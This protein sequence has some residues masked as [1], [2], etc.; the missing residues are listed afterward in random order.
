MSGTATIGP[1]TTA[2][3]NALSAAESLLR[4]PANG[5][6]TATIDVIILGDLVPEDDETVVLQLQPP[7]GLAPGVNPVIN[8]SASTSTI[9]IAAND[10]AAGV[11]DFNTQLLPP[12]PIVEPATFSL[13]VERDL[14]LGGAFYSVDVAWEIANLTNAL[15]AGISPVNGTV[16]FFVGDTRHA[17][18]FTV[19]EDVAPEVPLSITMQ[20]TGTTVVGRPDLSALA[21][22]GSRASV[23]LQ[24]AESDFPVGVFGFLGTEVVVNEPAT[25]T[26]T[27][28]VNVIRRF[29]N[30]GSVTLQWTVDPR[31]AADVDPPHAGTL[32]FGDGDSVRTQSIALAIKADTIPELIERIPVSLSLVSAVAPTQTTNVTSAHLLNSSTSQ[33]EVVVQANDFPYGLVQFEVGSVNVIEPATGFNQ[34]PVTLRRVGGIDILPSAALIRWEW[35]DPGF[36]TRTDNNIRQQSGIQGSPQVVFLTGSAREVNISLLVFPDQCPEQSAQTNLTLNSVSLDGTSGGDFIGLS[37][38]APVDFQIRVLPNGFPEGF[39]GVESVAAGSTIDEGGNFTFS[40]AR[41]QAIL[42]CASESACCFNGG[43]FGSVSATWNLRCVGIN[44]SLGDTNTISPTSGVLQFSQ[45]QVSKSVSISI[46]N[47]SAPVLQQDY[48]VEVTALSP[49]VQSPD[50][51]GIDSTRASIVV[52]VAES[53]FP[54]GRFRIESGGTHVEGVSPTVLATVFRDFGMVGAVTVEVV[55]GGISQGAFPPLDLGCGSS[56]Q[57]TFP[58]DGVT[59][60][61]NVTCTVVPDNISELDELFGVTLVALTPGSAVDPASDRASFTVAHS[62]SPFGT[63]SV[64]SASRSIT[65][66]ENDVILVQIERTAPALGSPIVTLDVERP[67]ELGFPTTVQFANGSSTA[68]FNVSVFDDAI[69][70]PLETVALSIDTFDG[71]DGVGQLSSELTATFTIPEHGPFSGVFGFAPGSVRTQIESSA[72]VTVPFTIVRNLASA[73]SVRLQLVAEDIASCPS[74]R[75]TGITIPQPFIDFIPGSLSQ[76]VDVIV[77]ADNLPELEQCARLRLVVIS[78]TPSCVNDACVGLDRSEDA[79]V[80]IP[81]NDDPYGLFA[82][83]GP[84]FDRGFVFEG[85]VVPFQIERLRGTHG[86][87]SGVLNVVAGAPISGLSS[88]AAVV[89]QISAT[90]VQ[91][92]VS[93]ADGDQSPQSVSIAIADDGAPEDNSTLTYAFDAAATTGNIAI[94]I[95][96][97]ITLIDNDDPNGILG[98]PISVFPR[99]VESS[100]LIINVTR[101]AGLF[102][103]VSADWRLIGNSSDFVGPISG[104]VTFDDGQQ[105]ASFSLQIRSDDTPETQQTYSVELGN[106]TGGATIDP[107]QRSASLTIPENDDPYGVFGLRSVSFATTSATRTIEV[108]VERLF[109]TTGTVDIPII[110]RFG[111]IGDSCAVFPT[112]VAQVTPLVFGPTVSVQHSSILINT[113]Y[114][115]RAGSTFCIELGAPVLRGTAT[116]PPTLV[117]AAQAVNATVPRIVA[118]TTFVQTN[119]TTLSR[120]E[121]GTSLVCEVDRIGGTFGTIRIPW[122]LAATSSGFNASDVSTTSAVLEIAH[123]I[124]ENAIVVLILVDGVPEFDETFSLTF[125][126]LQDPTTVIDMALSNLNGSHPFLIPENEFPYGLFEP[127]QTPL[128]VF[129]GDTAQVTLVRRGGTT[130]AF[131]IDFRTVDG[132]AVAYRDFANTAPGTLSF[133]EG[134]TSATFP[135]SILRP[136]TTEFRSFSVLFFNMRFSSPSNGTL[137]AFLGGG[138]NMTLPITIV[139]CDDPTSPG[140]SLCNVGFEST[141]TL[142]LPEGASVNLR[143][144]RT[145]EAFGELNVTWQL[146]TGTAGSAD[147]GAASQGGLLQ[148]AAEERVKL[149]PVVILQDGLPELSEQAS[150]HL[151]TVTSPLGALT[152][153]TVVTIEIPANDV[154]YGTIGIHTTGSQSS[155]NGGRLGVPPSARPVCNE[156]LTSPFPSIL[157]SWDQASTTC[158]DACQCLVLTR[159]GYDPL[160]S[161][162]RVYVEAY[163]TQPALDLFDVNTGV[164]GVTPM[165]PLTLTTSAA[166]C[167]ELCW[168][169]PTSTCTAFTV[170]SVANGMQE[171]HLYGVGGFTTGVDSLRVFYSLNIASR[172][173][174]RPF[175][176]FLPG[177]RAFRITSSS[178]LVFIPADFLNDTVPELSESFAYRIV[179]VSVIDRTDALAL[180]LVAINQTATTVNATILSN[181]SPHGIVG[182]SPNS[183]TITDEP[184]TVT[185]NLTRTE[186]AFGQVNVTVGAR[187]S[188]VSGAQAEFGTDYRFLSSIATFDDQQR[189]ATVTVDIL[190][191]GIP[192]IEETFTVFPVSATGGAAIDSSTSATLGISQND[193]AEGR[194]SMDCSIVVGLSNISLPTNASF[195]STVI[196]NEGDSVYCV[197]TRSAGLFGTNTVQF[198]TQAPAD[199]TRLVDLDTGLGFG[200]LVF[201]DQGSRTQ[202]FSISVVDDGLPQQVQDVSISIVAVSPVV[203]VDVASAFFTVNESDFPNG[204]FSIATNSPIRVEERD[205]Q[206]LINVTIVRSAG[207]FDSVDVSFQLVD[208]TTFSSSNTQIAAD[209]DFVQLTPVVQTITFAQGQRAA[210]VSVQIIDDLITESA[211]RFSL[212]LVGTTLG[213][214]S[215]TE[216]LIIDII[217][218]QS[219]GPNEY[220][221]FGVENTSI[222][223]DESNTSAIAITRTDGTFGNVTIT[224]Q[225]G[226]F[227]VLPLFSF[228][229]NGTFST[230]FQFTQILRTFSAATLEHCA[231][232]VFPP[233]GG[234]LVRGLT[235]V[236][237]N[238]NHFCLVVLQRVLPNDVVFSNTTFSNTNFSSGGGSVYVLPHP[239]T[240]G[241]SVGDLASN[242]TTINDFVSGVYSVTF[243][244]EQTTLNAPLHITDDDVPEDSER[245]WFRL[246]SVELVGPSGLNN[247]GPRLRSTPLVTV[248]IAANDAWNGNF[249]IDGASQLTMIEGSPSQS[250]VIR[251]TTSTAGNSTVSWR[252]VDH[253]SQIASSR[254]AL[255]TQSVFFGPGVVSHSVSVTAVDDGVV[256][257]ADSFTFEMI[258]PPTNVAT[259]GTPPSTSIVIPVD[260]AAGGSVAFESVQPFSLFEGEQRVVQL[261]RS[262]S[263]V[264]AAASVRWAVT[265]N[266]TNASLTN[267]AVGSGVVHFAPSVRTQTIS[268]ATVNDNVQEPNQDYFLTI[269]IDP[270]TP[271]ASLN[272]SSSEIPFTILGNDDNIQLAGQ[273]TRT[274]LEG[275]SIHVPLVRGLASLGVVTV[276]WAVTGAASGRL[277][278]SSGSVM[279]SATSLTENITLSIPDDALPQLGEVLLLQLTNASAG[280]V[281]SSGNVIVVVPG[282]DNPLGVFTLVCDQ[283]SDVSEDDTVG[284]D[285]NGTIVRNLSFV[286]S[287]GSPATSTFAYVADIVYSRQFENDFVGPS[288]VQFAAGQTTA[289]VVVGVLADSTPELLETLSV[290]VSNPQPMQ[291]VQIPNSDITPPAQISTTNATCF[292]SV[293]EN[294]D[295][296]GVFSISPFIGGEIRDLVTSTHS[297]TIHRNVSSVGVVNVSYSVSGNATSGA[298]AQV[299]SFTSEFNGGVADTQITSSSGVTIDDWASVEY[300]TSN[301]IVI[302]GTPSNGVLQLFEYDGTATHVGQEALTSP[303]TLRWTQAV[304][305]ALPVQSVTGFEGADGTPYLVVSAATTVVVSRYRPGGGGLVSH[306]VLSDV[307][308]PAATKFFSLNGQRF[309]IVPARP[310]S[311]NSAPALSSPRVYLWDDATSQFVLAGGALPCASLGDCGVR[312]VAIFPTGDSVI[313]NF[314][315]GSNPPIVTV[316][317][318]SETSNSVVQQL[319]LSSGA[320]QNR[321]GLTTF[322]HAGWTVLAYGGST[323]TSLFLW[324]VTSMLFGAEIPIA[325]P[326][327][328]SVFKFNRDLI[329]TTVT[330]STMTAARWTSEGPGVIRPFDSVVFTDVTNARV[331]LRIGDRLMFLEDTAGLTPLAT[332]QPTT[333]TAPTN[334]STGSSDPCSIALCGRDCVSPCGWSTAAGG[335]VTGGFTNAD[336]LTAGICENASTSTPAATVPNGQSAVQFSM[337]WL[338]LDRNAV[339]VVF[340]DPQVVQFLDGDTAKNITFSVVSDGLREHAEEFAIMLTATSESRG[341]SVDNTAATVTLEASPPSSGVFGFSDDD[342]YLTRIVQEPEGTNTSVRFTVQRWTSGTNDFEMAAANVTWTIQGPSLQSG[343]NVFVHTSGVIDF[344]ENETARLLHV[345]V[346]DDSDPELDASFNVVLDSVSGGGTLAPGRSHAVI[347]VN[348]SDTPNGG[349]G[350]SGASTSWTGDEPELANETLT[351]AIILDRLPDAFNEPV[352]VAY[353]IADGEA[354]LPSD[355]LLGLS[356]PASHQFAATSGTVVVLPTQSTTFTISLL[357]DSV[358]EVNASYILTLTS[359][360]SS[361]IG[362]L[363]AEN[364]FSIHVGASDNP[365]G[366]TS[367]S[368]CT[369]ISDDSVTRLLRVN[370]SR[371]GGLVR[372]VSG[373]FLVSH[374]SVPGLTPAT[375]AQLYANPGADRVF[376]IPN[377][378]SLTTITIA[379]SSTAPLDEGDLFAVRTTEATVPLHG[380]VPFSLTAALHIVPTSMARGY[381]LID[382]SATVLE[383]NTTPVLLTVER[384]RGTFGIGNVTV[385]TEVNSNL[386]VTPSHILFGAGGSGL[387]H[388]VAVSATDDAIPEIEVTELVTLTSPFGVGIQSN[389]SSTAVRIVDN[390]NVHGLF[391]FPAF[392]GGGSAVDFVSNETHRGLNIEVERIGGQ[393]G[394]ALVSITV[395]YHLEN[396]AACPNPACPANI[397]LPPVPT[398]MRFD[399]GV[400]YSAVYIPADIRAM[401]AINSYFSVSLDAVI[402]ETAGSTSDPVGFLGGRNRTQ[403]ATVLLDRYTYGTISFANSSVS[404]SGI[405][406]TNVT[407]IVTRADPVDQPT[408]VSVVAAVGATSTLADF[409]LPTTT[410][411]FGATERVQQFV[412]HLT[413]DALREAAEDF[414]LT[415][416]AT[417][418][419]TVGLAA[420]STVTIVPSDGSSGDFGFAPTSLGLTALEG[421][422]GDATLVS[423]EVTRSVGLS[424]AV[425]VGWAASHADG[426][427]VDVSPNSGRV[428]FPVGTS[429]GWINL[430]VPG[431]LLPEVLEQI[432]VTLNSPSTGTVI[433]PARGQATISVPANDG[434]FLS[435]TST[436][437]NID[438]QGTRSISFDVRQA[439]LT[440]RSASFLYS[441]TYRVQTAVLANA[442][443]AS[444]NEG[445]FQLRNPISGAGFTHTCSGTV[446]SSNFA[447]SHTVTITFASAHLALGETINITLSSASD[448]SS[449][450]LLP[451]ATTAPVSIAIQSAASDGYFQFSA[452]SQNLLLSEPT[453]GVLQVPLTLERVGGS[454]VPPGGAMLINWILTPSSSAGLGPPQGFVSFAPDQQV[455]TF[456]LT[457]AADSTP[458]LEVTSRLSLASLQYFTSANVPL[459]YSWPSPIS[460][461]NRAASP[462]ITVQASNSPHGVVQFSEASRRI[463]LNDFGLV[464]LSVE[465][466]QQ[467]G[468]STAFR[469][470]WTASTESFDT[471]PG[472]QQSGEVIFSVGEYGPKRLNVVVDNPGGLVRALNFTVRLGTPTSATVS[473]GA[474]SSASVTVQ[475]SQAAIAAAATINSCSFYQEEACAGITNSL[476][477]NLMSAADISAC[478]TEIGS[479]NIPDLCTS[480]L[481]RVQNVVGSVAQAVLTNSHPYDT[482]GGASQ[483][484][485]VL[486]RLLMTGRLSDPLREVTKT[487]AASLLSACASISAAN[488]TCTRTMIG[489]HLYIEV[490][491]DTAFGHQNNAKFPSG[492]STLPSGTLPS[493]FSDIPG[494]SRFGP[495]AC[496][497]V[498][499]I[500]NRQARQ[501]QPAYSGERKS[502]STTSVAVGI[503]TLPNALMPAGS[504]LAFRVQAPSR[505][506]P[507]CVHWD[508]ASS[509][510]SEQGC[511]ET[512]VS[513]AELTCA[514]DVLGA[515]YAAVS[516]DEDIVP[517]LVLIGAIVDMFGALVLFGVAVFSEQVRNRAY[518]YSRLLVY[519][520]SAVI[521]TQLFF[522]LSIGLTHNESVS[523]GTRFFIGMVL[524]FC[525]VAFGGVTCAALAFIYSSGYIGNYSGARSVARV[526]LPASWFFSGVLVVV[527]IIVGLGGDTEGN[528]D[529]IYGDVDTNGRVSFIM[530]TTEVYW[531]FAAEE[532]LLCLISVVIG[533]YMIGTANSPDRTVDDCTSTLP[534]FTWT[535]AFGWVVLTLGVLTVTWVSNETAASYLYAAACAVHVFLIVWTCFEA[536]EPDEHKDPETGESLAERVTQARAHKENSLNYVIN[537]AFDPPPPHMFPP[538]DSLVMATET[539]SP[540]TFTSSLPNI[541]TADT[542]EFDSQLFTLDGTTSTEAGARAPEYTPGDAYVT[543]LR[544]PD[545]KHAVQLSQIADTRL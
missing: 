77:T 305:V 420:T 11:F 229:G 167:A 318:W 480:E 280:V 132:T 43:S 234:N 144:L 466:D 540:G 405:E 303:G 509:R 170:R 543:G 475:F 383:G 205:A 350:V 228:V 445:A 449:N 94:P 103:A 225:T 363:S 156:P 76:L 377:G 238:A 199:G 197:V 63:V 109:G 165:H 457:L 57:I 268:I 79:S 195:G 193:D 174:A 111:S 146:V 401:F 223:V 247:E 22:I 343:S 400:G 48:V 192:E 221:S 532:V 41:S 301:A 341:S 455:R 436:S 213:H 272:T 204:I 439:D 367:V 6:S 545:D 428:V 412:V 417:A 35:E 459:P 149:I 373:R 495:N 175:Q 207:D 397:L 85:D 261:S 501:I 355:A 246:L 220:G 500:E 415:L 353:T 27:V 292:V 136:T 47:T 309:L 285:V 105:I 244:S 346:G 437:V 454:F 282:S 278:Q 314:L 253:N 340:P 65:A 189:S 173:V 44:C 526:S 127:G 471:Y 151:V 257:L 181:D 233:G 482:I 38:T 177:P 468:A 288:S 534:G 15:S 68:A 159:I 522:I 66:I 42:P 133:A 487:F 17:V 339:D 67:G 441:M 434:F 106:A 399:D 131:D 29:G 148:F 442:M 369:V 273:L 18:F 537:S 104:V 519:Y 473:V 421:D 124:A 345:I 248:T 538:A 172:N 120:V 179:N 138:D 381:A 270:S 362:I 307:S 239:A 259:I 493:R 271:L 467:F 541:T 9:T 407:L 320:S 511:Q 245:F 217:I 298:T 393:Q 112:V 178:D 283:P 347:F 354:S 357:G 158:R 404:V 186:G 34:L 293:F 488:C 275:T 183:F 356:F 311:S 382:A 410:V 384:V 342:V 349:I 209:W 326:G 518:N 335:C 89:T 264:P 527:F 496:T 118:T 147:F 32:V 430:T 444:C 306:Q 102:G 505:Y 478:L 502:L 477:R 325:M 440:P 528:A 203:P 380:D 240:V 375:D 166:G 317:R 394:V 503:V 40:V 155:V 107:Q 10:N 520:A 224:Y 226:D 194:F 514:C 191:D 521:F 157:T 371:T 73:G 474:A 462:E 12:Q 36:P 26:S 126:A 141:G 121:E 60:S 476:A 486:E 452:S 3:V 508:R 297:V 469:M 277:A 484:L 324:N 391:G 512:G 544:S 135:L 481:E 366:T 300:P 431:D 386:T 315:S 176:D 289:S 8:S 39:F 510:W 338:S 30:A 46:A 281:L 266:S 55:F 348:E 461:S 13:V 256:Q 90:H 51:R 255:A 137:A 448:A 59:T 516:N 242:G 310:A 164:I 287:R 154:P 497:D 142:V 208:Q 16:R 358:P 214:L 427:G 372:D 539:D 84:S 370:F 108:D 408:S 185:I 513:S 145:P 489:A 49:S 395:T 163:N 123:G 409:S 536:V 507:S 351:L 116:D 83:T 470:P 388:L 504:A 95:P 222:T 115:L 201:T 241:T 236:Y 418:G 74:A 323:G 368:S 52:S 114:P 72:N 279:F 416:V 162:V 333:S 87:V 190:A 379:L 28:L 251:R 331:P 122:N 187:N 160:A 438:A 414:T 263:E 483:V 211:E 291:G 69:P 535:L 50:T 110:V 1:G 286:V 249:V 56:T 180:G 219:D 70:E 361:N 91:I 426:S 80:R 387:R 14:V 206:E 542:H 463:F 215:A 422:V 344:R 250:I 210:V 168:Q 274:L 330:G 161:D 100:T 517:D 456:N 424:E 152:S 465:R 337:R 491:R 446:T 374:N 101:S 494:L 524:H 296:H 515:E 37:T 196:T 25:G 198:S 99:A 258:N 435:S 390:D 71:V 184:S 472:I 182:V 316:V 88:S 5:L 396:G 2:D 260:S 360:N 313:M 143:V 82:L 433:V 294:D 389:A 262:G 269:S 490:R 62:G 267:L 447:G 419:A 20:L 506:A 21:N 302:A 443:P 352:E 128:N 411:S 299:Y 243:A 153:S 231:R 284:S 429:V 425:S 7:T 322:S 406:G 403:R 276:D 4:F 54:F 378:S 525:A 169:E 45:G 359:T 24:L 453:S 329:L 385:S 150:I 523:E 376:T 529:V 61:M 451:V 202:S 321:R 460:Q 98:F 530:G 140:S 139:Q 93:F 235:F 86:L 78:V 365:F 336:E 290:S 533:A 81:D 97:S 319:S 364:T 31:F 464:A 450:S 53:D 432:L 134:Q 19:S 327:A 188:T 125:G 308:E 423:L 312:S 212:E 75:T 328:L 458:E 499:Y 227:S 119:C 200:T 237:D 492:S 218:E 265:A 332:T 216:P 485:V 23:Q 304:R 171:C 92:S 129:R 130:G 254:F 58:D 117:T 334:T 33:F 230:S 392:V 398:Q 96:S 479:L 252:I 413:D 498:F 232:L 402:L 531:A 295:V 64:A 113:T